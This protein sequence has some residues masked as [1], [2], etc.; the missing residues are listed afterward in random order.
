LCTKSKRNSS[1]IQ[2]IAR[3][4]CDSRYGGI[5]RRRLAV[6]RARRVQRFL[7]QPFHVAEQFTGLKGVLVDIKDT[8]KGFN[9]IIDGELDHLPE[10]AFNLKGTIEEAI[11]AGEKCWQKLKTSW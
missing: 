5:I 6:S 8:I 3:Y 11:E 1:K 2:A 9:M 7:S 4:Y 10:S